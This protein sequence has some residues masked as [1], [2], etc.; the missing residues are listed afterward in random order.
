MPRGCSRYSKLRDSEIWGEEDWGFSFFLVGI[1]SVILR[2]LPPTQVVNFYTHGE[3][4]G[5]QVRERV[6]E[7]GERERKSL[8]FPELHGINVS[9]FGYS[10]VNKPYLL[11]TVR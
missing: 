9:C 1:S 3:R 10:S 5:R 11:P 6:G 4:G 7:E 2:K 8:V